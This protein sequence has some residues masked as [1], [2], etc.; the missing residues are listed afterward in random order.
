MKKRKIRRNQA[1]RDLLASLAELQSAVREGLTARDLPRR[2]PSRTRVHIP[3]PGRHTPEKIRMLRERLNVSQGD[4]AGL[5]GVSR[6]LVQSWE[7]GVREPSPLA[8]RML[9]MISDDPSAWLAGLGR[10]AARSR[11]RAG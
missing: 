6:I 5:I 1:T 8:R 9:D 4:F 3:D 2:Y 10:Q 11:R 7:R